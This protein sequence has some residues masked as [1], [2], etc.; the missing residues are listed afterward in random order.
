MSLPLYKNNKFP[1]EFPK[2]FKNDYN[3]GLWYDKFC[4]KWTEKWELKG[5][6]KNQ[7]IDTVTG[8]P[9]NPVKIGKAELISE[10]TWRLSNLVDRLNGKIGVYKT[11]WRFVT[12][13]G[14]EHPVEN[15]FAWHHTLGTPYMPGSSVKGLVRSWAESWADLSEK[16][17]SDTINRIFGPE[18]NAKKN[19]GSV[20]FFDALPVDAVKLEK[21]VMTPHYSEYYRSDN[22][23]PADW[24]SPEPIVFLTVAPEQAFVFAVAPRHPESRDD[25]ETVMKWLQE[26]LAWCGAGAKTATGYGRLI[27]DRKAEEAWKI[28]VKQQQSIEQLAKNEKKEKKREKERQL[29]LASMSPIRREMEQDGYSDN[30][31]KFMASLS[32][33]WLNRMYEADIPFENSMEI[34]SLLAQWYQLYRLEQWQKPNQKNKAKIDRIKNVLEKR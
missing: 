27:P 31:E 30:Q 16:E 22:V 1:K 24:L 3:A 14:R 21:D 9:D 20:I 7:W 10:L 8:K 6:E 5:L 13:L 15:G 2:E 18:D 29:Y 33:K 12:G 11:Q 4:N 32:Q 23:P 26:A 19:V 25:V 34:A 17:K 28:K